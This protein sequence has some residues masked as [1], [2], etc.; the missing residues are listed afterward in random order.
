M[1]Q[2]FGHIAQLESVQNALANIVIPNA[3]DIRGHVTLPASLDL[4]DGDGPQIRWTSSNPD[5]VSDKARDTV[6]PGI[7]KRPPVGAEP[8][9]FNLSASITFEDKKIDRQFEL[10][11]RPS[12]SLAQLSRYGMA[13][14]AR[15]NCR[16]GQQ[17]FMAASIGNDPLDWV[18]VSDGEAVL[19][20]QFGMHGL[21]DPSIVRSPE[22]DKFYLV[23]TD[24]NVDGAYYG[25]QGWD[26]AQ[27]GAS[28]YIGVWESDDMS[29]WSKQRHVLVAPPGAGMAYAPESIWDPDIEAYVVYWTSSLYEPGTYF[30]TNIA[31]PRRRHPLTR[32]QTLYATTRD[33]VSFTPAKVMSG[34]S[35]APCGSED[36]Y[37]EKALSILAS[38]RDWTLVASGITHNTMCTPYAE[39]PLAFKANP[40][41]RRALGYYLFCD[42]IWSGAPAGNQMEEQL[43]PYWT[44]DLNSGSWTPIEWGQKPNYRYAQGVMRH[45]CIFGLTSAEHANLRGAMLLRIYIQPPAKRNYG[46][47]EQL[48]LTGLRVSALYSDGVEDQEIYPG[49]GGY[50][51]SGFVSD[52][53]GVKRVLVSYNVA[54]IT[55]TAH[56]EVEVV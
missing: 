40:G 11:V 6:P 21:R 42:Q 7:V 10:V 49:Y 33:F 26:W 36:V 50:A 12:V 19:T 51:V 24:L 23:A 56:F 45:G 3:H 13:N 22:G 14:F 15:S 20:S 5:I 37:Q 38:E 2:D 54:D 30:T 47:G 25:W 27:S 52:T 53:A 43:H 46:V 9:L 16:E 1:D 39:A 29:S 31:D 4:A 32:N 17:I 44:R 41:D 18:A 8:A 35:Y 28:R 48:D 34:Q 55:K